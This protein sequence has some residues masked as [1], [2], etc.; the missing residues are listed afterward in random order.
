AASYGLVAPRACASDSVFSPRWS[1]ATDIPPAFRARIACSASSR[2]WPAMNRSA[3]RRGIGFAG[4]WRCRD[5]DRAPSST[6]AFGMGPTIPGGGVVD[7]HGPPPWLGYPPE[8]GAPAA[9][10]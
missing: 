3:T 1:R 8:S 4:T 6:V 2:V 5:A 7:S 10:G 9:E